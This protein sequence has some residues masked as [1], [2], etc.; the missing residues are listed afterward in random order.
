[1]NVD[2]LRPEAPERRAVLRSRTSR[3]RRPKTHIIWAESAEEREDSS[4]DVGRG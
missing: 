4:E 1:M 2:D 3:R